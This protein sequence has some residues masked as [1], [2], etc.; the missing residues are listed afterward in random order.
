MCAVPVGLESSDFSINGIAL[1]CRLP[2]RRPTPTSTAGL[3]SRLLS[4]VEF[5]ELA[6]S[7]AWMLTAE[8]LL[9]AGS[10]DSSLARSDASPCCHWVV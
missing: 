6:A 8:N 4:G 5:L 9:L 3:P 1:V 10:A 7:G 2:S